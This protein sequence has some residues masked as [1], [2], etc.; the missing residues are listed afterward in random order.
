MAK[1]IG[2]GQFYSHFI[3][4]FELR[5]PTLCSITSHNHSQ[6]IG[7]L[8]TPIVQ[9][10]FDDVCTAILDDPCIERFDSTQLVALHTEFSSFGFGYC[11]L[12]PGDDA[13]SVSAAQDYCEGKVSHS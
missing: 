11:L 3:P 13:A 6:S 9:A 4:T 10:E 8:W 12:Q 1:F 2:F 5:I 7:D